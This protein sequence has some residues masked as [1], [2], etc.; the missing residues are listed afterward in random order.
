MRTP[1]TSPYGWAPNAA[2]AAVADSIWGPWKPFGNP[3]VGPN[4]DKTFL[5]QGTYML[6]VHGKAG[7][8]IFVADR[9]NPDNA[10]DGRYLWLPVE[11]TAEGLAIR[12]R[13]HWKL[14]DFASF[15][16]AAPQSASPAAQ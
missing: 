2:Y 16:K 1:S 3:S 5:G 11:F 12:W 7:A 8:F 14:S 15:A 6:P 13:D 4:A 9:W 10:I